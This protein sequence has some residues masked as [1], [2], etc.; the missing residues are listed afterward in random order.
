M[1]SADDAPSAAKK[2]DEKDGFALVG[3]SVLINRPRAELFGFWRDFGN[4][5]RFMSNVEA[6]RFLS[7]TRTEWTIRAPLGQEVT[8]ETEITAI[9]DGVSIA[10]ASTEGSQIET[11]GEVSFAD[12]PGGRGTVVTAEIAYKPPAGDVGRMVAKLFGAEP[13]I[14]ARHELKRFKMLMEAGEIADA[15]PNKHTSTIEEAA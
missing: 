4:L 9:V 12:A 14:Q 6:V 10:W 1:T 8:V 7:E 11:R 2:H 3:R 13:N 5:P 15:R